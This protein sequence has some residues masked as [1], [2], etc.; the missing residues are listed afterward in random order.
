VATGFGDAN[1]NDTYSVAGSFNGQP[2]Y[3]GATHGYF[4]YW[5]PSAPGGGDW[6]LDST[7]GAAYP[8]VKYDDGADNAGP[9]TSNTWNVQHGTSPAGSLA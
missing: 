3:R 9:K 6:A 1:A 7:L 2:Y 5:D 4:I 8:L